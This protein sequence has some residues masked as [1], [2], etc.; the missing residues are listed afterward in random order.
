MHCRDI[1]D[2]NQI[3]TFNQLLHTLCFIFKIKITTRRLLLKNKSKH[4]KK[5]SSLKLKHYTGIYNFNYNIK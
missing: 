3:V 2:S 1:F 4:L 5:K